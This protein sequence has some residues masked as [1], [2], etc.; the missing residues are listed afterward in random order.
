MAAGVDFLKFKQTQVKIKNNSLFIYARNKTNNIPI[1]PILAS[2]NGPRCSKH[3]GLIRIMEITNHRHYSVGLSQKCIYFLRVSF[4]KY[5]LLFFIY[6][7]N[8]YNRPKI[9]K[10]TRLGVSRC[11]H[12]NCSI[13][14]RHYVIDHN[15]FH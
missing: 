11:D 15:V 4:N 5:F 6:L 12:L 13:F 14:Y 1:Y 3:T 8:S 10:N 7:R 9:I 2:S